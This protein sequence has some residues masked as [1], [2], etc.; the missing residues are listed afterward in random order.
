VA[1]RRRAATAS[2]GRDGWP[3]FAIVAVPVATYSTP[4][5]DLPAYG[6]LITSR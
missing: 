6:A 5:F 4:E 3:P 1:L 2:G